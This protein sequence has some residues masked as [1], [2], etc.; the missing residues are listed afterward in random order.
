MTTAGAGRGLASEAAADRGGR[1]A[2]AG[3]DRD[4]G[5]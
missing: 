5:A 4:W 2:R 1:A 3:V